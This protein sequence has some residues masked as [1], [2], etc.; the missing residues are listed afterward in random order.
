MTP[1]ER[2]IV[3]VSTN[4]YAAFTMAAAVPALAYAFGL[5]DKFV[6]LIALIGVGAGVALYRWFSN[7]DKAKATEPTSPSP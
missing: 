6:P 2:Q 7:C 1:H 3:N 5:P 4:L